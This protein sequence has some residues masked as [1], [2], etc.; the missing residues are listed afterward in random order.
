MTLVRFARIQAL[1]GLVFI[2]ISLP[3]A[4]FATVGRDLTIRWSGER[5]APAQAGREFVGRFE[6]AAGQG[7]PVEGLEVVGNGWTLNGLDA[8]S[9]LSMDRGQ[10][11]VVT[12]RATPQNPA[13]PLTVRCVWQGRTVQRSIRL[14]AA[15]LERKGRRVVF[16]GQGPRLSSS[17]LSL[18]Q[19]A[20]RV[21]AQQI[22]FSGRFRYTR[23]DGL[24]VGADHIVIK[25]WDDD[26]ISDE[27]IWSG[28]TDLNGYFDVVVNWDDCDLAGC[29]DPDVYVEVIASGAEADVEEDDLLQTT[30]SWETPI[31]ADFTGNAID[32]GTFH[33][34]D[35]PGD[36]AVHIYNSI[37]KAHRYASD[38]HGMN[39]GPV[40]ILWPDND[41]ATAYNPDAQEI[42]VQP[43]DEWNELVHTHEFAHHLHNIFGN[44]LDPDYA[45][46]Y[47]DT[48]TPGHC[49]WCPEHVGEGWQEGFADWYGQLVTE[50]YSSTY[51]IAP[52]CSGMG[53]DG[54]PREPLYGDDGLHTCR[55]DSQYH[56]G[57]ETEGYVMALLRDMQ[58]A[59]NDDEDGGAADCDIDAMSLG[60]S[61]IL[62]VFKNDDPTDIGMFLNSFRARYP[63]YD[64]DLWSTIRNEDPGMGFPLPDPIVLTQ[65]PTCRIARAGETL[66][67]QAVGNGSLLKYQWRRNGSNVANGTGVSGATASTLFLS[68]ITAA[69]GGVYDCLVTTCDGTK[70]V[71]STAEQVTILPAPLI[72]RPYLAWGENY[73]GQCG[74]GTN[75]YQLPPGVYTGLSNVTQVD[76][77]RTFT[78]AL[79]S[80][81]T[82]YTWGQAGS[83]ELGDGFYVHN[84]YTPQQI[85]VSSVVQITAGNNFAFALLRDGSVKGWGSNFYGQ[86]GDSTQNDRTTPSPTKYSGC[87]VAMAAG[88]AHTLALRADGTVWASG[89]NNDGEL[90]LGSFG[91]GVHPYPAQVPGL[92]NVVAICA[93]GYW[94]MALRSDGT[95]WTWGYN[96]FGELGNG[97]STNSAV[98]VQVTGLSSIHSIA[99]SYYNGYAIRSTGETYAWGRG[100]MGAIGD[101]NSVY[102]YVPV[103]IPGILNPVKVV[104]GDA[105][106]AMALLQDGSLRAWGYNIN[107]VLWTG[108]TDG[109][110]RYSPEPVQNAAAVNDLAAGTAT[111]HVFGYMAG[112]TGVETPGSVPMPPALVLRVAHVPSFSSTSL[113]FDLPASGRVAIAIY[114]VSGRLVRSILSESRPAGHHTTRWDGRT[115]TGGEAPAGVYFARLEG[116]GDV[117]TKRIVLVK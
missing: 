29:D 117:V 1:V 107:S 55:D 54:L 41:D 26:P 93:A 7:G 68:P 2:L 100:D 22:H 38:L 90:G 5:P 66:T 56:P 112:V 12:F 111:A 6:I 63:Q 20:A 94:S 98:P 52:W 17:R 49:V 3:A 28:Q 71:T 13:E 60:A 43:Q 37:V 31:I 80:D 23:G 109:T 44:L 72:P 70:S 74:N 87:I 9:R 32:F 19:G 67:L 8:P 42:H 48:P 46:G 101:G 10:R 97:T 40:E 75:T 88:H 57:A 33:P 50:A 16:D 76:A 61:Q 114:D 39:P 4:V 58:D 45:N 99:A 53:N 62:D 73:G 105:G 79:R 82:V 59:T 95:V 84:V 81:G 64:Q 35:G 108:A 91:G 34:D 69:M 83:G 27:L 65:P 86:L 36:G 89:Y 24:A 85:G 116:S 30:Y 77:G 92:S 106:W 113:D 11:R 15:S 18:R 103:Q 51:G 110:Y 96:A 78:M 115:R 25:I 104:A 102:R 14:D 21:S 47:C